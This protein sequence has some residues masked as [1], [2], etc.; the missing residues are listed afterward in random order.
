MKILFS[1]SHFGFLRNL[2]SGLRALAARGHQI[3]L[4]ADRKENLGGVRTIDGLVRDYPSFTFGAGPKFKDGT[5]SALGSGLRLSQ[6]YWRY[7]HPRFRESPKLRARAESQAPRLAVRLASLPGLRGQAGLRALTAT[8]R[9]LDRTIPPSS[10]VM[11]LLETRRPDLLL[12]TPLLYFGSQQVDYVRAARR[13]GIPSGLCVGS[14][15]HLT[16]K[17]MIHEI[18]DRVIV[19]NEAQRQ[20]AGEIHGVPPDRVVVTGAQSYDHWF[21]A[22]PSMSREEFCR[23]I[24]L[25]P[26]RPILLYLCS[27]PFITPHEVGFVERWIRAVRGSLTPELRDAGILVR[28]HPQNSDQWKDVD[29][30]AAGAVIWPRAGANPVDAGARADYFD[31]MYYSAAVVGVNTSALIESGIVGRPVYTVLSEE[32]GSTQEG[33]LHFR[34]LKTVNGGLLHVARNF[35]EHLAQIGEALTGRGDVEHRSRQFVEAFVRPG[36]LDRPAAQNFADAVEH[37]A[38]LENIRPVP[39]SLAQRALRPLLH[40][41]AIAAQTWARRARETVRREKAHI[42]SGTAQ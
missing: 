27:S 9:T 31:S 21:L 29:L 32:F 16:T 23:R 40:P 8:F 26:E 17:G 41:L 33:T 12:V 1:T 14:W 19:W 20:E 30:S 37:L 3:H 13:L 28:P 4:I 10:D 24:G 11:A 6:D 39:P 36:G 35:D 5:W 42:T 22:Q 7:L 38:H 2:E 15:D 18:P 25:S 34:H